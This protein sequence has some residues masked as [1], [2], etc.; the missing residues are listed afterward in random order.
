[1][2]VFSISMWVFDARARDAMLSAETSRFIF[3]HRKENET[4]G[5]MMAVIGMK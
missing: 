1:M 3:L 4:T 5:R 2:V